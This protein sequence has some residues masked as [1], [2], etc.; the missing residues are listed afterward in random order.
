VKYVKKNALAGR[1]FESFAALEAH[2]STW[3]HHADRREHGTTHET[4][5]ARFDRDEASVLKPLPERTLPVRQ[6]RLERRVANDAFVDVDTIRYSVPHRLVRDNVTVLV[7]DREVRIFHGETLVAT[8]TRA[9]EPHAIVRD[10]AHFDGL[11]RPAAA[12]LEEPAP[13]LV[14]FGRSLEEYAAVIG[15][16]GAA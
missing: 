7:G 9:F 10:P 16:T 12:L 3:M 1:R 14:D 4:P 8:H 11:W 15:Q 6:R 13:K 5:L 2:L